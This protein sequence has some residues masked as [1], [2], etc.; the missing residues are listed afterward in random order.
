MQNKI[1][2]TLTIEDTDIT[3]IVTGLEEHC[4]I[5]TFMQILKILDT[6]PFK[7]TRKLILKEMQKS[8]VKI[9][10]SQVKRYLLILNEYDLIQSKTGYGTYIRELGRVL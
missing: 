7:W 9:S 10:E 6:S 8:N 4:F 1:S 3:D 5:S 2:K